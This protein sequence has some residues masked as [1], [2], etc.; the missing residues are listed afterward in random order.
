ME[1][2][3]KLFLFIGVVSASIFCICIVSFIWLDELKI[4]IPGC[5]K[6]IFL[7][8]VSVFVLSFA[9]LFVINIIRALK[10]KQF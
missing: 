10:G 3:G 2:R 9:V 8:A 6:F 4:Q 7:S 1:V 5:M